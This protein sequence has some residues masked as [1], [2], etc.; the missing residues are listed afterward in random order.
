MAHIG[1]FKEISNGFE[2][3]VFMPPLTTKGVRVVKLDNPSAN[4]KAPIPSH[5]CRPLGL[6]GVA[7]Y[8]E[9]R[10]LGVGFLRI[11]PRFSLHNPG[12]QEP[13]RWWR[14]GPVRLSDQRDQTS[15]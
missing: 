11:W 3:E 12:R 9:C 4:K 13:R 6:C 14:R 7:R 15:E 8:A 10:R 2:G 1:T 5:L